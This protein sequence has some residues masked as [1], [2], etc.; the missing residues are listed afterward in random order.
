M[1][2]Y[3]KRI[4]AKNLASKRDISVFFAI[5][6]KQQKTRFL[7]VHLFGNV[8]VPVQKRA[9]DQYQCNETDEDSDYLQCLVSKW[10]IIMQNLNMYYHFDT[11]SK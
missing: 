7:H 3:V 5:I 11:R 6:Y 9:G 8:Y 1:V 10:M 4:P 2:W